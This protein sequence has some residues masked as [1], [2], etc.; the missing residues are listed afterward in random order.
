MDHLED[1]SGETRQGVVLLIESDEEVARGMENEL[2]REGFDVVCS[3]SHLKALSTLEDRK[4]IDV[5]LVK[6]EPTDIGGL[7]FV[8]LLR[9]RNRFANRIM[10][11]IVIASGE[12]FDRFPPNAVG[13]DDYLLR[14]YF[15]GELTWRVTKAAR[16]V[17]SDGLRDSFCLDPGIGIYSPAGLE[18]ILHEEL[19]KAFRKKETLSLI[20]FWPLGLNAIQVNH[21]K[22]MA[23]WMERDLGIAIRNSLRSYDRLGR[24]DNG[25][26]CLIAPYV[27]QGHFPLLT[28]RLAQL[29]QAWSSDVMRHSRIQVPVSLAMLPVAATPEYQSRSLHIAVKVFWDWIHQQRPEGVPQDGAVVIVRLDEEGV[30]LVSAYD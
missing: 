8:H 1:M 11:V 22:V 21:G 10:Q 20:L 14:P 2:L 18:K 28:E 26:Y 17:R 4:D 9:H 30:G 7:D 27:D 6:A 12:Y 15:P 25:G 16:I 5:V 29:V 13:I 19:N 24:L 23:E 3:S